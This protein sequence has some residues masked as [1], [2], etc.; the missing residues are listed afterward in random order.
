MTLQPAVARAFYGHRS[1]LREAQS[2]AIDPILAGKDTLVLAGTGSGKTEA[3]VAP[4]VGRCI[5]RALQ[6]P[7]VAILYI[8]PT[9]ALANDMA[10]RLEAPLE[11]LHLSVGRRHGDRNDLKRAVPPSLL[12][13]TPESFDIELVQKQPAYQT[14]QTVV[15]D[16]V[17]QLAGTQRGLQLCILLSRL[18]RWLG[19]PI[20]VAGMSA[21]LADPRAGWA[22]IRPGIS[23]E[24][25]EVPSDRERSYV[26]RREASAEAIST[27]LARTASRGKVLVFA[28]SRRETEDLA[29]RMGHD[30]PFGK[31]V[32]VHHS[33]LDANVREQVE[34]DLKGADAT[35]C[36]ATSTLE[37][38]IDIGDINLVGLIGPPAEWRS[39]E[40]RIGR[41]NRRSD[42]TDVLGILPP[43]LDHPLLEAALFLGLIGQVERRLERAEP[44]GELL[45]A[46]AQQAVSVVRGA[47]S[48]TPVSELC[49]VLGRAGAS[50]DDI[51][52]IISVL[53]EQGF[54]KRHSV[55]NQVGPD[56]EL[57][58][59]VDEMTAWGNFPAGSAV[60]HLFEGTR[61]IG[62]VP[63][64]FSNV[65]LLRPGKI[66][67]FK[68]RPMTVDKVMRP[69]EIRLRPASGRLDG[70]LRFDGPKPTRDP[71][72]VW[73]LPK[74]LADASF[75]GYL[76]AAT[77]TW[78]AEAS[79]RMNDA[80]DPECIPRWRSEH[81][82]G[83]ATFAGLWVNRVIAAVLPA[84]TGADDVSV[85]GS[86]DLDLRELPPFDDVAHLAGD[87]NP[88]HA[89][90]TTWQNLLPAALADREMLS[91]WISDP[92]YRETWDTIRARPPRDVEDDRLDALGY[93][94]N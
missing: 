4:V 52:E 17:H 20:Q 77:A 60:I 5:D 80:L 30:S 58:R 66:L 68:G 69:F 92:F 71:R 39:F 65:K 38:G 84:A 21:T 62:E 86:K 40:Q 83:H 88:Q 7:G 16:E 51:E 55:R 73:Q 89:F 9:K 27:L 49:D 12:I 29:A 6:Q 90:L 47:G 94:V 2:R 87:L 59:A 8:S 48:W 10:S 79:E 44:T 18:E 78:W 64:L 56:Q 70:T 35:L 11:S 85:R 37:L 33:S 75:N 82:R 67:A 50:R 23:C 13:T 93:P 1:G 3:V 54:L 32:Y 74:V 46:L 42:K 26:V 41:T 91:P 31:R 63:A 36:V 72:L 81:G 14:I 43:S 57:Y 76:S 61:R 53:V 34:R 45:G 25:I 22:T 28:R 19:H 24:V 15:V